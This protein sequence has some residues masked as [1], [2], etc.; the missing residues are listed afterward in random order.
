[1]VLMHNENLGY[2]SNQYNE[3]ITKFF[4]KSISFWSSAVST[5][6]S[7]LYSWRELL[8]S[9]FCP[10]EQCV[11]NEIHFLVLWVWGQWSVGGFTNLLSALWASYIMYI[12]NS[13]PNYIWETIKL[14]YYNYSEL[15]VSSVMGTKEYEPMY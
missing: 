10:S 6:L 8:Q 7:F 1:M 11:P 13:F 2:F 3:N 14:S 5:D 15:Y 4:A 12:Q 9:H